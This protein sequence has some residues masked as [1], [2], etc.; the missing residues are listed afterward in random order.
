MKYSFQQFAESEIETIIRFSIPLVLILQLYL[1]GFAFS[2]ES[3]GN[4][5]F[6]GSSVGTSDVSSFYIEYIEAKSINLSSLFLDFYNYVDLRLIPVDTDPPGN[7]FY[8][9]NHSRSPPLS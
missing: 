2:Y 3:E 1:C 4:L 6:R 7:Y 5:A 9:L 8:T